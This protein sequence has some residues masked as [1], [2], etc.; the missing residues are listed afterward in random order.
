M[1]SYNAFDNPFF[2]CN[3]RGTGYG[4]NTKSATAPR[5]IDNYKDEWHMKGMP[6][7]TIL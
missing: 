4:N 5:S 7:S 3:F 6:N 1:A 2:T